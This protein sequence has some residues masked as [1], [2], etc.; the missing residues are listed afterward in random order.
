LL[1]APFQVLIVVVIVIIVVVYMAVTGKFSSGNS[2]NNNNGSSNANAKRSAVEFD[3]ERPVTTIYAQSKIVNI[4]QDYDATAA[5][6]EKFS[7][8][9]STKS[10]AGRIAMPENWR[11]GR[12][13]GRSDMTLPVQMTDSIDY[14]R[15]TYN[16]VD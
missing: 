2:S 7:G 11:A 16:E 10:L 13:D 15:A 4:G 3:G 1:T 12:V 5:P 14:K 6:L 9:T 8:V